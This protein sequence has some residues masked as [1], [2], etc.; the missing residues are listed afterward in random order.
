MSSS[1]NNQWASAVNVFAALW[2]ERGQHFKKVAA[3]LSDHLVP[4]ALEFVTWWRR[5]QRV[6]DDPAKGSS[7]NS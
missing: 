3:R 4:R 6:S 1:S 5:R 2:Q 7:S